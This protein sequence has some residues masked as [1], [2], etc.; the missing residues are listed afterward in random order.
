[1]DEQLYSPFKGSIKSV[2][3]QM[4]GIDVE[5]DGAF[6]KESDDILSKGAAS[7]ISFAGSIKGRLLIDFDEELALTIAKVINA[8][9]FFSI[10]EY[11]VL[12]SVSEVNNIVSGDAITSLNNSR[13]LGLRLAPPIVFAGKGATVCIPKIPSVSLD[14]DTKHGKLKLNVAFERGL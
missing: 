5:T 9:E 12:A 1:M 14:C 8:Q 3:S 7:I 6:Y 11:L 13:S 2:L 4:A 10:K